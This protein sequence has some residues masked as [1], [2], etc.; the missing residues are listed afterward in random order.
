MSI[1]DKTKD[2]C[3]SRICETYR[4]KEYTLQ[5]LYSDYPL[6]N[7]VSQIKPEENFD[8]ISKITIAIDG[9]LVINNVVFYS[10]IFKDK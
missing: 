7:L 9:Y 1:N 5:T 2:I 10:I 8:K 3:T 4:N 6:Q